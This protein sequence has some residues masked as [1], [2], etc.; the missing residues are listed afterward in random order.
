[1]K[2]RCLDANANKP[3][4]VKLEK[5]KQHFRQAVDKIEEKYNRSCK[6][7]LEEL[8]LL[9]PEI[10]WDAA[11]T[12]TALPPTQVS[13]EMIFSALKI[14]KYDFRASAK[15]DMLH[16][17][18]KRTYEFRFFCRTIPITV[19]LKLNCSVF[20]NSNSCQILPFYRNFF[21]LK[22]LFTVS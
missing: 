6:L 12:V 4:N 7:P 14:I 11:R 1:M 3:L 19:T 10:I 15:E 20:R 9:Y 8:I 5:F 16:Y 17:S 18:L 13:A 22:N 2:K 21:V